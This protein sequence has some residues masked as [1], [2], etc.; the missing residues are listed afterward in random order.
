MKSEVECHKSNKWC[1]VTVLLRI[2]YLITLIRDQLRYMARNR[3]GIFSIMPAIG[4]VGFL[5]KR[6]NLQ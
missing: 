4:L 3:Y 1:L 6:L 5:K 2:L